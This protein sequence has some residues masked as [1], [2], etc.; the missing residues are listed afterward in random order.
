[1]AETVQDSLKLRP[2]PS[3]T[4]R[5]FGQGED[6][7]EVVDDRPLVRQPFAGRRCRLRTNELDKA[8]ASEGDLEIR[9]RGCARIG[10]GGQFSGKPPGIETVTKAVGIPRLTTTSA[11]GWGLRHRKPDSCV[12]SY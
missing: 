4:G 11:T 8:H 9:F 3:P 5:G 10:R 1:M 12:L 2:I 7:I 6:E